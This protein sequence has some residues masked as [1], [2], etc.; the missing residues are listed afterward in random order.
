MIV[1]LLK[2]KG[3]LPDLPGGVDVIVVAL[4]ESARPAAL[5]VAASLREEAVAVDVVL[6]TKKLKWVFKQ[7]ERR[8]A[9]RIAIVGPDDVAAGEYAIKDLTTGAQTR[10]PLPA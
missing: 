7:A 3:L 1:E 10:L 6:E 8:G 2:D 4:D 9:V 5:R